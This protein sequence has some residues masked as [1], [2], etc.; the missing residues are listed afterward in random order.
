MIEHEPR[1]Y[2]APNRVGELADAR[3]RARWYLDL[4]REL[5]KEPVPDTFLGRQ[6]YELIPPPDETS[7]QLSQP[8]LK[9]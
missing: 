3:T 7:Y 1:I 4:S 6:H 9:E 8:P 5:L 2:R